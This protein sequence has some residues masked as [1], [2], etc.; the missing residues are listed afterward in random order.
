M[1]ASTLKATIFRSSLSI[2]K[3]SVQPPPLPRTSMMSPFLKRN[4]RQNLSNWATLSVP[5]AVMCM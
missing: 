4:A 2:M 5:I 3:Y 1:F